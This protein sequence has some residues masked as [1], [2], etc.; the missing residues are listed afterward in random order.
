[1]LDTTQLRQLVITSLS[2]ATGQPSEKFN[3]SDD[4]PLNQL[5]LDSMALFSALISIEVELKGDIMAVPSDELSP[6]TFGG[7]VQ[8]AARVGQQ[9]HLIDQNAA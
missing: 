6:A 9:T 4:T 1:M 3:V 2:D 5:T 7:V 8:L